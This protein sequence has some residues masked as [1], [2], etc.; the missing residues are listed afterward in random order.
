MNIFVGN[1]SFDVTET[2]LE[3]LFSEF[4]NVSSV[5]IIEDRESGRPRGF[6]FVEMPNQDEAENAIKSLNEKE[7]KGR[8]INVTQARPREN[9]PR[10]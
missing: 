1:M 4:G 8:E 3:N 2:E 7:I 9:R 10:V 5:K 6:A